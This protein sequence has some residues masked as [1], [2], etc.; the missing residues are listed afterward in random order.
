M[1]VA[2]FNE[3]FPQAEL[4]RLEQVQRDAAHR[5]AETPKLGVDVRQNIWHL[6]G[7]LRHPNSPKLGV[8]CMQLTWRLREIQKPLKQLNLANG[9]DAKCTALI[10]RHRCLYNYPQTMKIPPQ[11]L[12][13]ASRTYLIMS[14]PA[15]RRLMRDFKRLQE[16]P[17][18]GVSGAPTDNNIMIWN[19]VIF[20]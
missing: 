12:Y 1:K 16:D 6:N 3:T 15:R 10:V 7:L 2:R 18:A 5:A 4:R 8:F 11:S 19:A 20:G 9:N 13:L 17:P 14:T